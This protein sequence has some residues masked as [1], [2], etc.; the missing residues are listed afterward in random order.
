MGGNSG[1]KHKRF[2]AAT[3]LVLIFPAS[4]FLAAV[5]AR[6]LEPLA[7]PAQQVV[8]WYSDRF[9]TL[10]VLLIALPLAALLA[11]CVTLLPSW[12]GGSGGRWTAKQFGLANHMPLPTK[13]ITAATL[14]SGL[15]L[16]I[17]VLHML[18]N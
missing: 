11:G 3:E 16:T 4:L 17:V 10:W 15:I 1:R 8:T 7:H 5:V 9:W 13:I 12:N 6:H 2:V 14:G 18:A